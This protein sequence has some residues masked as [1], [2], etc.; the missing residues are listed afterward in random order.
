MRFFKKLPITTQLIING[1][2]TLIVLIAI[3]S[4]SYYSI[5]DIMVRKNKNYTAEMTSTI[6]YSVA[7]YTQELRSILQN[8]GYDTNTQKIYSSNSLMD[9]YTAGQALTVMAGNMVNIKKDIFDIAIIGENGKYFTMNGNYDVVRDLMKSVPDDGKIYNTGF[10]KLNIF[11]KDSKMFFMFGMYFYSSY[12]S[13]SFA[14]KLGFASIMV[15]LNSIFNEINKISNNTEIKYYLMD[16]NGMLYAPKDPLG[17]NNNQGIKDLLFNQKNSSSQQIIE[18]NGYKYIVNMSNIPEIEGKIVSFVQEKQLF[19]EIDQTRARI[20]KIFSMSIIIICL[21]F[22]F[23]INNITKP[24]Q[25]LIFFMNNIK[26]GSIK[27]LRKKVKLEGSSEINILEYEF[28][29]MMNE[30]NNL[31]RRLFE[32]SSKLYEVELQKDKAELAYLRSQINPHF[33]YNTLEVMK[34]ISLE[35][36]VDK[37]YE[38]SKALA[39]IFRYSANGSNIVKLN[40]EINI[41]RAYIQIHIIRFGSRLEANF[42]FEERTLDA[43]ILKMILQ[44]LV[45]NAIYHGIEPKRDKGILWV[46]SKFEDGKL[47]IWVEDNGLG[48][49]QAKLDRIKAKLAE[50]PHILSE[51]KQDRTMGDSIGI[52]NVNNRL[53][54]TYGIQFGLNIESRKGEGTRVTITIPGIGV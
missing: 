5:S 27:D 36:G 33:L 53:K 43:D 46:G 1:V 30:I 49:D 47:L 52:Y 23:T 21:L 18:I 20:L 3:L 10:E 32:T 16:K 29:S 19:S 35:E 9:S 39:L 28:N 41:I 11:N 40:D 51:Q 38:M 45:E 7:R 54:L 4:Q 8:I 24:I 15:D 12:D 2:L 13:E 6:Q 31:T 42:D 37:L 48:I 14:K 50:S 34:G 26:S 44:P 25:K 17:I 22:F